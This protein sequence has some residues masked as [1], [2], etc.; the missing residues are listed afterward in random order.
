MAQAAGFGS[1]STS[2]A[3]HPR[4]RESE[5]ARCR[6]D[7]GDGDEGAHEGV[8][9]QHSV[10]AGH[11]GPPW[12]DGHAAADVP[13]LTASKTS[14]REDAAAV[15]QPLQPPLTDASR[16]KRKRWRQEHLTASASF[17]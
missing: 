2:F 16:R 17:F 7:G 4:G 5:G 13:Q 8:E 15:V 1:P 11:G 3:N 6:N 10:G 9:P 14:A 12:R